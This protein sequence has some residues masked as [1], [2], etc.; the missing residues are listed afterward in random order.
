V[1]LSFEQVRSL[2]S[3]ARTSNQAAVAAALD[4]SQAG[5]PLFAAV[6]TQNSVAG[7]QQAFDALSGEIHGSVQAEMLDDSRYLRQAVLGRLRQASF[8]GEAGPLAALTA[9]GPAVAFAD[10]SSPDGSPALA[11]GD[12]RRP[13]FPVKGAP[14]AVPP[15]SLDLAWWAQGV[16]AW[17]T[18][19]GNGN[20]AD[21]S[22]SLAGFFTGVDRRFGDWRAGIAGGYTNADVR[23]DARASA[24]N[25]DTAHLAAYAG[26]S[27][28]VWNLRMGAAISQSTID[29]SR[30]VLFPGFASMET[31]RYDASTAQVF[32]EVGYGVTFGAIAAEPFAGLA[33]TH[34]NVGSF[35]E[36]GGLA[37][38]TGSGTNDDVGYSTLGA[39]VATSI[40]LQNGMMITPRASLA[41]QHA[42]GDLT[43]GA[44]LAFQST[45]IGFDISGV[46][47]ASDT[48]LVEGGV[49]LRISPNVTVGASYTGQFGDNVSDHAV[50]GNLTWRF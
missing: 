7:A 1:Q 20:A 17:G 30:S 43:P 31:A 45:G 2:V 50:K 24:A 36:S 34:L 6:V 49:D 13:A 11:Y 32:G 4:A 38:L 12:T 28:G 3:A 44:M 25:V 8:A 15:Q 26:A 48:A 46:P 39:R 27:Y 5:S 18:I 29:S 22:R 37:A 16:G 14:L 40:P 47:L 41:W 10:S 19:G 23:A 35:S 42:F 21:V 9:G 33:W